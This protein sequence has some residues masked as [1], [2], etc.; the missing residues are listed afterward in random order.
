MRS[1]IDK[2]MEVRGFNR[3]Y[4]ELL[5]ILQNKV[6][7]SEYSLTETRILYEI[8]KREHTTAKELCKIVGIDP[9]HMS[10]IIKKFEDGGFVERFQGVDGRNLEIR[11]TDNG[12][13]LFHEL[14]RRANNQISDILLKLSDEEQEA[15]ITSIVQVKRYLTKATANLE[16][17][18]YSK[19]D[20][21]YIIGR[22]LS[23]YESE[24]GFTSK[25]WKGYLKNGVREMIER[26]DETRDA[27]FILENNGIKSGCAAVKHDR[28]EVAQFR[29]FF[30]EPEL[31]GVGAG[32]KLLKKA[33]DFCKAKGY[34]HIFLWTVS[35][36]ETAR[37]LYSDFG[38]KI[39]QTHEDD[40]WGV[41]VLEERWDIDI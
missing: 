21:W 12:R 2:V 40:S 24:R 17:R 35:A 9:S 20:E 29:Y 14:E 8:S 4:T 6:Y 32:R 5:G 28:D 1:E 15:L 33:I 38:F 31:R 3:F 25:V 34:R 19:G 27:V 37:K 23:L 11:L 41:K 39:T 26:F 36:Q 16:I 18:G 22:Q 13:E 10:R 30:I 7:E